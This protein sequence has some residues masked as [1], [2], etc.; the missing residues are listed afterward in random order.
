[1]LLARI[2]HHCLVQVA[3]PRAKPVRGRAGGRRYGART[4][5]DSFVYT[6]FCC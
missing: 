3:R 1:L 6:R 5:G 2:K 4:R